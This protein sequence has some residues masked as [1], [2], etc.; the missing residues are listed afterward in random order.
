MGV[1][2]EKLMIEAKEL[3]QCPCCGEPMEDSGMSEDGSL[4][5]APARVMPGGS[6]SDEVIVDATVSK[7]CD[8][9]ERLWWNATRRSTTWRRVR[10]MF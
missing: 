1:R 7:Y 3:P 8:L 9:M 5:T 10:A 6:Y 4:V 2:L